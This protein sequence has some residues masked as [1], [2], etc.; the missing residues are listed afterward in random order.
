M[1]HRIPISRIKSDIKIST[2]RSGGAGGQHVNKVETKVVLRFDVLKSDNLNDDE[3]QIIQTKLA[4]QITN[5]GELI[6][7]S[8]S[9]KSQIRNKEIAFEKL[10]RLL[11]K[12]FHVPKARKKTKPSKSA[13]QKRI[14]AK[15][16][17]SEKK[18]WRL[19]P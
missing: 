6:I 16:Q 10:D 9:H 5:D 2:A 1:S 3:K 7:T 17:Q 11:S 14:K 8:E 15:K 13:V 12:V 19:K 18:K 4:N